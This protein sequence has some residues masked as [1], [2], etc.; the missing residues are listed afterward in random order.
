MEAA[1]VDR[2]LQGV[3]ALCRFS[4]AS[5]LFA[6]PGTVIVQQVG[7]RQPLHLEL[8][9]LEACLWHTW[10]CEVVLSSSGCTYPTAV[11]EWCDCCMPGGMGD[12][13]SRLNLPCEGTCQVARHA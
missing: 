7:G 13:H 6:E 9:R 4:R 5:F 11:D 2:P 12:T 3:A 1:L 10:M 8:P